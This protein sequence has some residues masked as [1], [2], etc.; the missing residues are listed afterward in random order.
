M[1]YLIKYVAQLKY[2]DTLNLRAASNHLD[3]LRKQLDFF[4][5][6]FKQ[7]ETYL[8]EL[9]TK[10][11]ISEKFKEIRGSLKEYELM[12]KGTSSKNLMF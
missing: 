5:K 8:E 3:E 10:G 12:E 9:F 11:G 1:V 4:K 6:K 7:D 2:E